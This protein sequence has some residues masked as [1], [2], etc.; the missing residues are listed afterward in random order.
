MGKWMETTPK[1]DYETQLDTHK[2]CKAIKEF[3]VE[4]EQG[5]LMIKKRCILMKN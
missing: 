5:S 1:Q 4:K 2:T 3:K